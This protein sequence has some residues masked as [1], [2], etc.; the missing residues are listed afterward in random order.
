M[1]RDQFEAILKNAGAK[2]DKEGGHSLS[3]GSSLAVHVAHDGAN[4]AFTKV[5]HLRF[6]GDLVY[7][8]SAKQTI[9]IVT[10]DVFA[11]IVEGAGGQSVRRP[12]GFL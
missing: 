1:T 7:A 4:L 6:D 9:A 10:S 3:D 2:T 11:V 12:A 8:R 5:E